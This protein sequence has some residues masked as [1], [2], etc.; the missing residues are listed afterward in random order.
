MTDLLP[1]LRFREF[2]QMPIF[3]LVET[4]ADFVGDFVDQRS[5]E[6]SFVVPSLDGA[7][8]FDIQPDQYPEPTIPN[9]VEG[10][11]P[12][13]TNNVVRTQGF[14]GGSILLLFIVVVI[15]VFFVVIHISV[16]TAD[17]T[18]S[19]ITAYSFIR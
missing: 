3:E 15:G 12:P 5:N 17:A 18:A 8:L 16:R 6:T 1:D 2:R 11:T 13:P 19:D 7:V 9:V 10:D 4:G 14:H